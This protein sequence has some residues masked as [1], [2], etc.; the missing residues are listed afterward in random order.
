VDGA[1]D[2]IRF[3]TVCLQRRLSLCSRAARHA[4]QTAVQRAG[5]A[6]RAVRRVRQRGAGGEGVHPPGPA[7]VHQRRVRTR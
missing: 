7:D 2:S 4:G 5:A 3:P 6:Q 1:L